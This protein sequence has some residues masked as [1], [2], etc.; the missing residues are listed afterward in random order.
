MQPLLHFELESAIEFLRRFFTNIGQY[1]ILFNII[2][3][4][5]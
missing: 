4:P 2:L 3:S 5:F 1:K